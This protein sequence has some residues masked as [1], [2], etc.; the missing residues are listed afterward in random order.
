VYLQMALHPHIVHV[1]G[2]TEAHHAATAKEVVE[3]CRLARRA[4]EN[5]MQGAPDMTADPAVQRRARELAA[6]AQVTLQA[7]RSIAAPGTADPFSDV[8][9]LAKAVTLGILDAPQL[10][11]NPYGRGQIATRMING[12][13]LAVQP[14]GTPLSEVVRLEEFFQTGG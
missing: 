3:S 10:R 11:N 8:A 6:E 5:H 1:V 13:C 7:I 2:Y 14:D 9:T 12:T 4:I